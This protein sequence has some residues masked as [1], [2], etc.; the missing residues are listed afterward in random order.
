M[1]NLE[2]KTSGECMALPG[3]SIL[4]HPSAL[5]FVPKYRDW[6]VRDVVL[7]TDDSLDLELPDSFV[8][9]AYEFAMG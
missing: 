4:Y 2:S 8:C 7:K 6:C 1:L 5:R 3:P 9:E